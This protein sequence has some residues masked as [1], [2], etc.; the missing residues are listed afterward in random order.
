MRYEYGSMPLQFPD[1]THSALYASAI[2]AFGGMQQTFPAVQSDVSSQARRKPLHDE[3]VFGTHVC[4]PG[5]GNT[6]WSQQ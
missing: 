5:F 3:V 4:I 2:A 6:P 1:G